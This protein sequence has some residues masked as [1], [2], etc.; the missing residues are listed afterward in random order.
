MALTSAERRSYMNQL[1][2]NQDRLEQEKLS[3]TDR[4]T[5]TNLMFEALDKLDA[6]EQPDAA[7]TLY[8][9]IM[10]GEF[11]SL[12][13]EQYFEKLKEACEEEAK[14]RKAANPGEETNASSIG[15]EAAIKYLEANDAPATD[16]MSRR[17]KMSLLSECTERLSY[18]KDWQD[19]RE[20]LEYAF[21]PTEG[22]SKAIKSLDVLAD[23]FRRNGFGISNLVSAIMDAP[24]TVQEKFLKADGNADLVEYVKGMSQQAQFERLVFKDKVAAGDKLFKKIGFSEIAERLSFFTPSNLIVAKAKLSKAEDDYSAL[25]S[26]FQTISDKEFN[27]E[28]IRLEDEISAY[29]KEVASIEENQNIILS[30][31]KEGLLQYSTVTQ[32]E[33]DE[34][35]V[36]NVTLDDSLNYFFFIWNKEH[37]DKITLDIVKRELANIYRITN[38]KIN[39]LKLFYDALDGDRSYA[40]RDVIGWSNGNMGSL[41]HEAGHVFENANQEYRAIAS[42]FIKDR[43]TGKPEKLSKLTGDNG[44]KEDEIAYPDRFSNP[45]VGKVYEDE[46]HNV[47]GTE[48]LS[49]GLQVLGTAE[50][51]YYGIRDMEHLK[52]CFGCFISEP[53]KRITYDNATEKISSNRKLKFWETAID[54]A[55]PDSFISMLRGTGFDDFK[56]EETIETEFLNNKTLKLQKSVLKHGGKIIYKELGTD[57]YAFRKLARM[58]YLAICSIKGIIPEAD[59][60]I[61]GDYLS[62]LT[63]LPPKW[64][65]PLTELPRL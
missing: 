12:P 65:T 60:D 30:K 9:R 25:I 6:G 52:F 62:R 22:I 18:A 41:Y 8:E 56:I 45:Y 1:F 44:Y 24:W 64:F 39:S 21:A 10:N 58:A 55:M 4:R 48:V 51:L 11:T 13:W 17:H 37:D 46:D 40:N 16:S 26:K 36:N 43:A 29:E 3:R 53:E 49:M 28:A 32:E 61:D 50:D 38:G 23:S 47:T 19:V 2:D 5:C 54:N 7:I 20:T 59:L 42:R 63:Y 31:I 34:W 33:A 14:R 57:E 15:R 27:D 35:V